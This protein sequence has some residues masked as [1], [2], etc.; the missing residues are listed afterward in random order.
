MST[1][2][3]FERGDGAVEQREY[4][5]AILNV[6]AD[7]NEEKR[8]L[9]NA[10]RAALNILDDA[11][12]DKKQLMAGHRAVLNILDDI[13]LDKSRLGLTQRAL[14]NVLDDAELDKA[15]LET[16]Q[17]ALLNILEDVD[18][19]RRER[20]EAE[21]EVRSLNEQLEQRVMRRTEELT[22]VNQELETFAY[23]VS[24]DLRTPLRAIDGFSRMLARKYA[25]SLDDEAQRIIQVVRDS[26]Q[27]MSQLID[28]IL[29]FSRI[30]RVDISAAIVDMDELVRDV[31]NELLPA[32]G[33]RDVRFVVSGLPRARGDR[34]MLRQVWQNLLDNAVKYTATRGTATI[35]VGSESASHEITYYVKDNGVGF[36]MQYVQKLFGVFRRLHGPDEFSGTGIG[37]AIV[38]RIVTRHGG[39]VWAEGVL[40]QGAAFH[41]TLPSWEQ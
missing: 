30:G 14:L 39:R 18:S 20:A 41:F 9:Q 16:T 23:S 2:I 40:E 37:L 13:E 28:D 5:K 6:L 31:Q 36:D 35:C 29:A 33:G 1:A 19:E 4:D 25:E 3:R 22:A 38:K 21:T 26:T 7:F 15:Q 34:A 10:Q 8:A 11:E 32:I 27:K 12:A 17:R 24:H